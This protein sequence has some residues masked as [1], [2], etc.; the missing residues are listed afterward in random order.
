MIWVVSHVWA[1][2]DSCFKCR[3]LD[4]LLPDVL[5]I[6]AQVLSCKLVPLK[7]LP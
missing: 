2:F 7:G 3:V 1:V 4:P 5:L 6:A